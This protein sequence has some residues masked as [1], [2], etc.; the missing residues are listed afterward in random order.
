V[1]THKKLV[2]GE[3]TPEQW[4]RIRA[5]IRAR[6]MTF[7]VFLPEPLADWLGKKLAAGVFKDPGEAAFVAFQDLR[8]LDSHP[9]ARKELL[10]AVAK[11]SSDGSG[12]EI[13]FEEWCNQ[14]QAQLRRY[15]KGDPP[16][17]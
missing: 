4:E 17:K 1:A 10:K 6:G 2:S 5:H 12:R 3:F 9:R 15:A 14:H 13:P 8:E 11:S 7:E 16:S